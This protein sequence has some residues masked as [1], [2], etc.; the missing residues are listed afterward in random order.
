MLRLFALITDWIGRVFEIPYRFIQ[1]IGRWRALRSAG[2]AGVGMLGSEVKTLSPVAAFFRGVGFV[3]LILVAVAAVGS[4]AYGLWYLNHTWELERQLG[5]PL[6]WA[7]PY[8]LPA[9]FG[10]FLLA[11]VAGWWLWTLVGPLREPT[12]FADI[13]AAWVEGRAALE[14]NGLVLTDLPVYLVL[15]RPASGAGSFFSAARVGFP[16]PGVPARGDAPIQIYANAHGIYVACPKVSLLSKWAEMLAA[17]LP[18]P[19]PAAAQ[20]LF[21]DPK[22]DDETPAAAP[23]RPAWPLN[24]LL[25]EDDGAGGGGTAVAVRPKVRVTP[26]LLYDAAAADRERARLRY[27]G[28]LIAHNRHPFCGVN[29]VV[30]LVPFASLDDEAATNQ[31]VTACKLDL[32]AVRAGLKVECPVLGVVCDLEQADGAAAFFR[33]VPDDRKDRLL[34]Q[35]FPLVPDLLADKLPPSVLS[36]L[37]WTGEGLDRIALRAAKISGEGSEAATLQYNTGLCRFAN[38]VRHREEAAAQVFAAAAVGQD[39]RPARFGGGF[40]AATGP[41]PD[42]DQAFVAGLFRLLAEQQNYVTWTP[43]AKAEDAAYRGWT[44]VG[45]LTL[46]VFVLAVAFALARHV[47]EMVVG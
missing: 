29:G 27:L 3:L 23:A 10:L 41:D 43:A 42:R 44:A 45:Y 24:P 17:D 13:Y 1:T 35:P 4:A 8:W 18:P 46:F 33:A 34:G 28:R 7:R 25:L 36:S 15:G 26:S 21:D 30:L 9:L 16:V 22:P 6:P 20:T 31:A 37:R 32:E 40:L 2:T 12:D 5:G 39:G 14:A 47:R 11:C 19:P 38:A